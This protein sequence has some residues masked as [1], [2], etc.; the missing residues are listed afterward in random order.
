MEELSLYWPSRF[1]AHFG[2]GC[3]WGRSLE[4]LR[5]FGLMLLALCLSIVHSCFAS[6]CFAQLN[7]QKKIHQALIANICNE[8]QVHS[9]MHILWG[10]LLYVFNLFYSLHSLFKPS[11]SDCHQLPKWGRLKEHVPP[12]VVLVINYNHYGLMVALRFTCRICPQAMLEPFVGCK[13]AIRRK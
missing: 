10:S 7:I 5:E 13:I 6:C 9:H 3:Q 2:N 12:C 11:Q 8:I 1:F 4:G